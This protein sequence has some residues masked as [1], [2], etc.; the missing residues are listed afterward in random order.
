MADPRRPHGY[1]T[2]IYSREQNDNHQ[3]H[4][5]DEHQK[6]DKL[7]KYKDIQVDTKNQPQ[8]QKHEE[9]KLNANDDD[10]KQEEK[11]SKHSDK[12]YE[13][14]VTN[15]NGATKKI[16]FIHEKEQKLFKQFVEGYANYCFSNSKRHREKVFMKTDFKGK[17]HGYTVDFD[18]WKGTWKIRKDG[19]EYSM[20]CQIPFGKKLDGFVTYTAWLKVKMTH[21]KSQDKYH[22]EI[23]EIAFDNH[24][25]H[26]GKRRKYYPFE[27]FAN[28]FAEVP[29]T[30][31]F[32]GFKQQLEWSLQSRTNDKLKTALANQEKKKNKARAEVSSDVIYDDF[33]VDSLYTNTRDIPGNK[34]IYDANQYIQE[35]SANGAGFDDNSNAIH[36][37]IFDLELLVILALSVCFIGLLCCLVGFIIGKISEKKKKVIAITDICNV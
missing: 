33:A 7:R 3:P 1:R 10:L 17:R 36:Q 8:Q 18:K 34:Q 5:N 16:S 22:P 11:K 6:K 12:K 31:D 2:R 29:G 19:S 23:K 26:S 30:K 24:K 15:E 4:P 28:V 14:Q 13:V 32:S 37:Q 35:F 20:E 9:R 27:F 21:F 25:D